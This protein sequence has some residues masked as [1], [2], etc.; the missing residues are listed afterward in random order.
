MRRAIVTAIIL[1]VLLATGYAASQS[2]PAAATGG[3]APNSDPNALQNVLDRLQAQAA[4]LQ[5][6]QCKIDYVFKQIWLESQSRR[7]GVLYYAKFDDRSYLRIDFNTL[8][9]NEEKEQKSRE[10]FLFDGVW[11]TYVDHQFRSVERHQM[12]EPNKP[13]DAFTL[14][15]RRVPVLGFTKVDDLERQFDIELAERSK[16]EPSAFYQLHMKVKPDSVYKDD[17]VTV[18]FR[19]D[20]KDGL[21]ARIV[22]VDTEQDV[23]EIRLTDPKINEGVRRSVFEVATPADFSVES[24]PLKRNQAGG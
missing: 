22:A 5:S 6:Y 8:Q 21:P 9:Q 24:V 11:L 17:Y 7:K 1:G 13:V 2:C 14:V 12:A 10:Q 19:I 23:H 4:D 15:S 18:D 3:Q 16:S 20:K